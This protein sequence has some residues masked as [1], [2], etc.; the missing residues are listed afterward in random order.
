MENNRGIPGK[1]KMFF[2]F[3]AIGVILVSAA[4]FTFFQSSEEKRA[5][6]SEIVAKAKNAVDTIEDSYTGIAY[7]EVYFLSE[8][9]T[10]D[11]INSV[12]AKKNNYIDKIVKNI[13]FL[14]KNFAAGD[15][16]NKF[17]QLFSK[18]GD[19]RQG[20]EEFF[21]TALV[22]HATKDVTTYDIIR[23]MVFKR[24]S[25]NIK[26]S[27]AL[28]RGIEA[29]IK[30]IVENSH[31]KPLY[32]KYMLHL[33]LVL[34]LILITV[35]FVI[36]LNGAMNIKRRENYEMLLSV[37]EKNKLKTSDD[38]LFEEDSFEMINMVLRRFKESND[39]LLTNLK[40][41]AGEVKEA[42]NGSVAGTD[43]MLAVVT[44][45]STRVSEQDNLLSKAESE[46][47][48]ESSDR[49]C[50]GYLNDNLKEI[51]VQGDKIVSENI[52]NIETAIEKA[53][54][55]DKI[56]GEI[57]KYF[58]EIEEYI[59]KSMD[60]ALAAKQLAIT[61]EIEGAKAGDDTGLKA[62]AVHVAK[63]SES[64]TNEAA[65][66]GRTIKKIKDTEV[67][68]KEIGSK[69]IN[70]LKSVNEDNVKIEKLA[71][72]IGEIVENYISEITKSDGVIIAKEQRY[73]EI[74][75]TKINELGKITAVQSEI[76]KYLELL[77]E[78]LKTAENM[79]EK[80]VINK[81]NDL[82]MF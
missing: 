55:A 46:Y 32:E 4:A 6:E 38:V 14:K 15:S 67:S 23:N 42:V 3:A 11:D 25:E 16:K 1:I 54:E 7:L 44:E 60:I 20:F 63:L 65:R 33:V 69:K 39:R 29:D 45:I 24:D 50:V 43:K 36:A 2:V 13:D 66:I 34:A 31:K 77:R 19:D 26:S 18:I 47:K 75:R 70:S 48:Y 35:I 49:A 80:I 81:D 37:I 62:I 73:S 79:D 21:N 74:Y 59:E 28:L 61:G 27:I 56:Y 72:A 58:S 10:Q 17:K 12:I 8:E 9:L 53:N 71:Y 51:K 64:L 68:L 41:E 78:T 76:K 52:K 40:K 30:N 57:T 22:Y 5:K 82:P